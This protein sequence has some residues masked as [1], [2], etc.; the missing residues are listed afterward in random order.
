MN[1]GGFNKMLNGVPVKYRQYGKD[2]TVIVKNIKFDKELAENINRIIKI[3]NDSEKV[4]KLNNDLL[5]NI[6]VD[7]FLNG[8]DDENDLFI[9]LKTRALEL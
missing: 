8:F 1:N 9:E 3:F 2:K 5:I 4:L 7:G 6:A